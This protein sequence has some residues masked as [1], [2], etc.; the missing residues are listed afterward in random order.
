M[1]HHPIALGA[2]LVFLV[3]ILVVLWILHGILPPDQFRLAVI[4]AVVVFAVGVAALWV[5]AFR[6]LS[7]PDSRLGRQMILSREARAEDGYVASSD[8]F[9]SMVGARGVAVC[10]LR[11][12]GI[13]MFGEK[14]VSVVTEGEF[15]GS[16]SEVEIASAQGSRVVV[17]MAVPQDNQDDARG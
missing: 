10:H 6:V 13:A 1:I 9:S 5:M 4:A 3:V 11:P 15:I 8:Q 12:V 7:N 2:K 17:R 16:G 14:R